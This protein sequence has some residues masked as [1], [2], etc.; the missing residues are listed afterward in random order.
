MYLR[1]L[2]IVLS[3]YG[4]RASQTQFSYEESF[5]R[6][7]KTP[8][9]ESNGARRAPTQACWRKLDKCG[10]SFVVDI[11]R[12]GISVFDP[13]CRGRCHVTDGLFLTVRRHCRG[14]DV[15]IRSSKRRCFVQVSLILLSKK[16]NVRNTHTD[17]SMPQGCHNIS[18]R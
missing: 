9:I 8:R 10:N 17:T 13:G 2:G 7:F 4:C 6:F 16:R 14:E 1:L 3:R 15:A 12:K 18:D 11:L 5:A